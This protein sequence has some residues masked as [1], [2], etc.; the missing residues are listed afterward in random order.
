MP[1]R[2]E[3]ARREPTPGHSPR[4]VTSHKS[5]RAV[6]C[7]R[8]RARNTNLLRVKRLCHH[9]SLSCLCE[10]QPEMKTTE[11]ESDDVHDTPSNQP[12]PWAHVRWLRTEVVRRH[13]QQQQPENP[14]ST[15]MPL[16]IEPV[17]RKCSLN[18]AGGV[19]VSKRQ[20]R[21]LRRNRTRCNNVLDGVVRVHSRCGRAQRLKSLLAMPSALVHRILR[22]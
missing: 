4:A 2:A 16:L 18:V 7:R 12:M 9:C 1:Y 6:R 19:T 8:P 21:Q 20:T 11:T 15:A 14:R 5:G 13:Q 22:M 17:H 10:W 3:L